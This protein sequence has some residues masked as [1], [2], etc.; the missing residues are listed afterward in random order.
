M[1]PSLCLQAE[2]AAVDRLARLLPHEHEE[3]LST[4]LRLLLNLS[5]D[6][7]LRSQMVQAGLVPKLSSLLGNLTVCASCFCFCAFVCVTERHEKHSMEAQVRAVSA[8]RRSSDLLKDSR[9]CEWRVVS[10]AGQ[11][12]L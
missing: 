3:L 9:A 11:K 5:F 12:R 2:M 1:F 8:D 10:S 4:T 7:S 6:T